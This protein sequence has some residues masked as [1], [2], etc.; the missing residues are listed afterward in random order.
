MLQKKNFGQTTKRKGLT[1]CKYKCTGGKTY[2]AMIH[3]RKAGFK[4]IIRWFH[5][6]VVHE[7]HC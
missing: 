5:P 2:A 3:E 4:F 6:K 1:I 7:V